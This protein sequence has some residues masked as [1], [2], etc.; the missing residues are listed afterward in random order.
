MY[1]YMGCDLRCNDRLLFRY[2]FR[3]VRLRTGDSGTFGGPTLARASD[4]ADCKDH[5]EALPFVEASA[6]A[7]LAGSIET[8]PGRHLAALSAFRVLDV[9]I[10]AARHK[11]VRCER[12]ALGSDG[13]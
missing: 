2:S 4:F 8:Q 6:K 7:K 9:P 12:V 1:H 5:H 3:N 10:I 11:D 13:L